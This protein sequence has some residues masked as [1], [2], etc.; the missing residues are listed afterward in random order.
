[1]NAQAAVDWR[2]LIEAGTQIRA[3]LNPYIGGTGPSGGGFV[4]SPLAAWLF[5]PLSGLGLQVWKLLHVV[6]AVAMP[7]RRLRAA[8]L[9]CFSF[10]SEL[11]LGNIMTFAL[12]LAAWAL[13]GQRW[14]E[15]VYVALVCLAPKPILLP[16]LV[17][18]IWRRPALMVKTLIVVGLSNLAFVAVTGLA[19]A[20]FGALMHAGTELAKPTN[21][22]PSAIVGA[23]WIPVGLVAAVVLFLRGGVVLASL[24]VSPYWFASYFV[25]PVLEFMNVERSETPWASE[26][27]APV[28]RFV[29]R[30]FRF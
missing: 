18:L 7:T 11:A 8:T 17:W 21:L 28:W 2:Q 29:R 3:G 13:R 5:V 16:V 10:W 1:M 24:F 22:A 20:W 27:L 12:L 19:G 4:W 15:V 9:L 26:R 25:M 30:H 14:A 6:A 23:I